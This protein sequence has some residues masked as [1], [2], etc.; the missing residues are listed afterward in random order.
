MIFYAVIGL[1]FLLSLLLEGSI[2]SFFIME[3]AL[4]DILLVLVI[5]LGFMLG[6]RRGG[7]L[8]LFFGLLQ[9]I[10]FGSALG[11]FALAKMILGYGAGLL[12]RELYQDQLLAPVLLVFV[13]TLAHESILY[14]LVN[15]FIGVG[16]PVELSLSRLFIPKSL[17]NMG[18]TLFL[19]PLL[20]RLYQNRK[21]LSLKST[22]R[23]GRY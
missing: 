4:P 8:G 15:Q 16:M 23:S 20:Y 3:K 2:L 9:D 10:I 19:Y 13:G 17:Y 22:Q 6:E 7:L 11:F 14:F 5:S 12:G 18:L 1:C 21:T